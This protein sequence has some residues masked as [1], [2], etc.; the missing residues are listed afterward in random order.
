MG[1][2]ALA[3]ALALLEHAAPFI[4]LA[5]VLL[6]F[7][8]PLRDRLEPIFRVRP[9]IPGQHVDLVFHVCGVHSQNTLIFLCVKSLTHHPSVLTFPSL[10][11]AS[12]GEIL[13]LAPIARMACAEGRSVVLMSRTVAGVAAA[14]R[15]AAGITALGSSGSIAAC[16]APIDTPS[17]VAR[18][19]TRFL[20]VQCKIDDGV[21][22]LLLLFSWLNFLR[23]SHFAHGQDI[24]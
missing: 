9:L 1:S 22:L 5:D 17:I 21:L 15:A 10:Q 6:N 13:S 20:G 14:R 7:E 24:F 12:V 19:R 2:W 16:R 18:F 23:F 8:T 4:T 11:G 3:G